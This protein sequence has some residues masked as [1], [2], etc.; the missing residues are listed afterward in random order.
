MNLDYSQADQQAL[1]NFGWQGAVPDLHN[2]YARQVQEQQDMQQQRKIALQQALYDQ[3]VKEQEAAMAQAKLSDPNYNR[4]IME[5]AM[6]TA[7]SQAVAGRKAQAL[8]QSDIASGLSENYAKIGANE[9]QRISDELT[10]AVVRF[11]AVRN[12]PQLY[13]Q[14]VEEFAKK[15]PAFAKL[16]DPRKGDFGTQLERIQQG[17]TA[18]RV[19]SDVKIQGHLQQEAM[20]QAGANARNKYSTD[21]QAAR[22]EEAGSLKER[23]LITKTIQA[24]MQA[25]KTQYENIPAGKTGEAERTRLKQRYDTLDQQ[26]QA[27]RG[28]TPQPTGG[29]KVINLDNLK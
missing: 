23:A 26:L 13:Q 16:L 14:E 21:A 1:N 9:Q 5:G 27:L 15:N 22:T 11:K 12:S 10:N 24:S 17:L 20:Q 18:G 4:S 19:A 7:Q 28:E 25:L 3:K 2:I 6:G 29:G 8:E